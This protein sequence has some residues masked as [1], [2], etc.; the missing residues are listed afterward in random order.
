VNILC[1]KLGYICAVGRGVF[2]VES[3][4]FEGYLLNGYLSVL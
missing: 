1:Y 3:V 4:Y 2:W